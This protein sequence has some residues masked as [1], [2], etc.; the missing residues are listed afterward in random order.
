MKTN[1]HV[2]Y[3]LL[4]AVVL[5]VAITPACYH[6]GRVDVHA[7]PNQAYIYVDGTPVGDAGMSQ[8][9][10][11]IISNLSS[12]EHTIGLYHYG[13]KPEE[14]KVA[15]EDGKTTPLNVDMTPVGGNVSG[16][17][18]RI[19]IEGADHAAVLLNGT[20]PEYVIGN[21]DEFDNNFVWKQQLLV[22]PGTHQLTV[23]K[24]GTTLYS[25]KVTVAAN[26][27]VIV[28]V[29]GNKQETASWPEG[30]KLSNLPRFRAG[31]ASATD[32]VA[33]PTAQINA[34]S[35]SVNCGGSAKLTW[36]STDAV[37][38]QIEG[39]G[40]VAASGEQDVSPKDTT[41]YKF[42]AQGPGGTATASTTVNVDKS[43]QANLTVSPS[44]I[45]YHKVGN[46]V[47]EQGSA[48]VTW[49]TSNADTVSVDPFGSVDKSGTRT[50]QAEP[51]QTGNGPI[52]ETVRYTLNATNACGG[53]ETRTASL[54]IT[55]SI[56]PGIT[57][58]NVE[59]VMAS[60]FFPTAFPEKA[61]AD[62]G[63]VASQRQRLT[64]FATQFKLYLQVNPDARLRLDGNADVRGSQKY[65][66]ALTQRRVDIVRQF[67][68]SQGIPESAIE[69]KAFGKENNLDR[70][71]VKELTEKNP[72]KPTGKDEKLVK[73][74]AKDDW[75]AHNRR[76]D[77]VLLP[78]GATS[79][80]FYPYNAGDFHLLWQLRRP[81]RKAVEKAQ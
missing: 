14:R 73:R 54:H 22:P 29:K 31:I 40:A 45:T 60:V 11:A 41:T 35:T 67:L 72:N 10:D 16:P 21:A 39:I 7:I 81:A 52:D 64:E 1:R 59:M 46:Q 62:V 37:E 57:E 71:A 2:L 36:S 26:Q 38:G 12:G 75:L 30:E 68:V 66:L 24:G 19:Q 65:N 20:K 27:R 53:S 58:S 63:L 13:Y 70:A 15:V 32:A 69:V 48:T 56:E 77:I 42:D 55:G 3:V 5:L 17:W 47:K 8:N 61:A 44:E 80:R 43:V 18:G 4:A 79:S 51:K 49:S 23:V 6:G 74:H 50:V 78:G 34:S 76:V 25:G 33:K 28:H 9:H